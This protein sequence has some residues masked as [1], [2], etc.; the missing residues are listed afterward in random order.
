MHNEQF[1]A[2][3]NI[4]CITGRASTSCV[5]LDFPFQHLGSWLL[6]R[7]TDTRAD[8]IRLGKRALTRC[9]RQPDLVSQAPAKHF[10]HLAGIVTNVPI[11]FA[12]GVR[13]LPMWRH[14]S[15]RF[16]ARTRCAR[17]WKPSGQKV[18]SHVNRQAS[19]PANGRET[20]TV[21]GKTLRASQTLEVG[22]TYS[23]ASRIPPSIFITFR[24]G[25]RY[26]TMEYVC[27]CVSY[28][29]RR[30]IEIFRRRL[31]Y[32]FGLSLTPYYLI[33]AFQ[34]V[35][36]VSVLILVLISILRRSKMLHQE[37]RTKST[38][39]RDTAIYRIFPGISN[40]LLY[41]YRFP[42]L[43]HWMLWLSPVT[44]IMILLHFIQLR[45]N[46]N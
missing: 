43:T 14:E 20:T 28:H 21:K 36:Y 4:R 16:T 1:N 9:R 38:Q 8:K 10:D 24:A 17:V 18:S 3:A 5:R 39:R 25:E 45:T 44:G 26:D 6:R 27:R 12:G 2:P 13:R 42:I 40:H 34:I 32:R 37:A 31:R 30:T 15:T 22:Q 41:I 7:D 11:H 35:I 46:Y 19:L 23:C 29:L 33:R